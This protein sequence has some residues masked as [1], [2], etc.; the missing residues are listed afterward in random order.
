MD[1]VKKARFQM[2]SAMA[3]FGTIGL[4]VRY[5]PL[6]SSVIALARGGIGAVFL[7][8]V[9]ALRQRKLDFA[10]IRRN[11]KWLCLAGAF[12]G[13]NWIFL[14]EA[15]RYTTV[16][17]ATLCY[18]LAPFLV[19]LLS[20]LVLKERLT[21]KKVLCVLA[22]LLGMVGVSGVMQSGIPS[23]GEVKGILLGT[24]A[25]VL[26]ACIIFF[27]KQLSGISA[28]DRTIFQLGFSV[29]LMLPYCLLT[30]E[31]SQ[32]TWSFTGIALLFLVAVVHTGLTYYL[33]FGSMAHL[34]GQTVAILSYID[35]VV[36]IFCSV[37]LLGEA[38][39]V[40]EGLG[41]VLVLGAAL[42]SELPDRKT[43]GTD[44]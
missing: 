38:M 30:V 36:A 19:I 37:F 43:S 28:Y 8:A 12:L 10:A 32:L 18:Y 34:S 25:A 21:K 31:K 15:Y 7:L 16:A 40:S 17:T 4:F 27:N 2:I 5:I 41:A 14:F 1:T 23:S 13:F 35:P 6:P 42:I 9:T 44:Q 26:Y 20:P 24:L 11:L 29:L 22:A 39:T 33:Y 3:L